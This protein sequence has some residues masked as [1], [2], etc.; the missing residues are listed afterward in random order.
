MFCEGWGHTY[1][2]RQLE[3]GS[4]A[5]PG[6]VHNSRISERM[7]RETQC[8]TPQCNI[9]TAEGKRNAS[10]LGELQGNLLTTPSSFSEDPAKYIACLL[11]RSF[12]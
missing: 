5:A 3:L 12:I 8:K 10:G 4:S 6:P 7:L 2:L 1:C 11:G 9:T